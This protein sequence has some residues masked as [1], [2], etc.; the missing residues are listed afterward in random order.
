MLG[1]LFGM[2]RR[3]GVLIPGTEA[4]V[5]GEARKVDIGDPLAD[6]TQILLCRVEGRVYALD[7]RCPHEDGRIQPG[8][9]FE[10]KHALC[11]LHNYRF[12][13]RDGKAVDVICRKATTYRVEERGGECEVF[14]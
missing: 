5:E 6:G 12:D 8:P 11:P 3:K 1:K 2:F 13:V 4:L 10:G 7:A 9:L 14:L